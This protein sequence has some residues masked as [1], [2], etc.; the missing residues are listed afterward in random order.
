[1]NL[2]NC[3]KFRDSISQYI[4]KELSIQDIKRFNIHQ[5]KCSSCQETYNSVVDVVTSMKRVSSVSVS[6]DFGD[7]LQKRIRRESTRQH[8]RSRKIAPVQSLGLEPRY[9][10][11][12]VA[13]VVAILVITVSFFTGSD[14]NI[15]VIGDTPT[16]FT[17]E[18]E[19]KAT[20]PLLESPTPSSSFAAGSNADT[21]S[22]R[23]PVI[24]GHPQ[25]PEGQARQVSGK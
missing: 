12:S 8:I 24:P 7:R 25:I 10:V 2:M 3:Y 23:K 18:V 1:M 22:E 14:N 17:K 11:A 20:I 6:A 21:S 4:D 5:E 19:P 13:A 15:P 16:L 9:A